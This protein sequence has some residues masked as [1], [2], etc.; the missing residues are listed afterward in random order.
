MEAKA[1]LA[2]EARKRDGQ[3]F[4]VIRK[5]AVQFIRQKGAP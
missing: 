4:V 2:C 3:V 5:R 1:V